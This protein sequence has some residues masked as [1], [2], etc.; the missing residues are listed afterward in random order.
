MK[1]SDFQS[2]AQGAKMLA[3]LSTD[4]P[5]SADFWA[6]YQRGLRRHYH[7]EKFGTEDEHNLWMTAADERR[8]DQRRYRGIGYRAGIEGQNIQQA[9]KTLAGRQ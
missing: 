3:E 6:G 4:D 7:G 2:N 1:Q 5:H 9:M 8:D